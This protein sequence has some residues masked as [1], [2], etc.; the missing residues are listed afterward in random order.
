MYLLTRWVGT[1][2]G[3]KHCELDSETEYIK[4]FYP[5][6]EEVKRRL[7]NREIISCSIKLY[8]LY[9]GVK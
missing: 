4:A 8:R 3:W 1:S 2:K 7:I 9:D 6:I 5:D